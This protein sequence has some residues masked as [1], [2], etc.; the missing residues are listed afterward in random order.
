M[1]SGQLTEWEHRVELDPTGRYGFFA[2]TA[3]ALPADGNGHTDFYRRDLAGG[4]AGPLL[5][6][7]ANSDGQ[8][9][10]GPIG[11]VASTEYGRLF[12]ADADRVLVLTSQALVSADTNRLRD[13]YAKDLASG[14]AG[15]PL[16]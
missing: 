1:G 9:V 4:V 12:A 13:L 7:T 2:T 3:A 14:I 16:G 8:V 15:S 11:A 10:G 6:V 5:L